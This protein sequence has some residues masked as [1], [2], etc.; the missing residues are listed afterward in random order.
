MKKLFTS[1]LVAIAAFVPNQSKADNLTAEEARTAAA[2]YLM[3]RS[4]VS[5][6]HASEMVLVRQIDNPT[7]GVPAIYFFNAPK[8]G[9]VIMA[10]STAIDP[11]VAYSP[12]GTLD[13]DNLPEN[14]MWWLNNYAE[15]VSQVQILDADHKL[16]ISD[17]WAQLASHNLP[18]A[19]ENKSVVLM[20][21]Y[22][23]QGDDRSPS[24]NLYCPVVDGR[25]SVVGCV[26]TALSQMCH[27]YRYPV[28]PKGQ[29]VYTTSGVTIRLKYD[30]ISFDYSL[31]PNG[32]GSSS[33]DA[34]IKEVA[35]LC[36]A[37]GVA[38]RMNYHPDGSG[39][40]NSN[41]M[42]GM[43]NIFKYEE[44]E[45]MN[46]DAVGAQTFV[47][48]IREELLKKNILYMTGSSSIGTGADAAG[49]A[50]LCGGYQTE[51][52]NMY[53]MNWGWGGSRYGNGFYNLVTNNM[54]IA[55]M[56][57]NF[58]VD[59]SILLGLTPPDDSNRF[60]VGITDVDGV[61]PSPAYPNPAAVNVNIPY[62]L[63]AAADLCIYGLDGRQV[64]KV[65]VPAGEGEATISVT[66]LPAGI[67]I[68]RL[69]NT[70]G[71][72]IVK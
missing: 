62:S 2:Y 53:W 5:S 15:N 25:T 52:L 1:F 20:D 28:Q 7:L 36:Y 10:A 31:M 22:W 45:L 68:Y 6:F 8:D 16:P 49:H 63:D 47:N 42:N 18:S 61:S 39:S 41:A 56:G 71:K 60:A 66:D 35:K 9:W 43:K 59:Q 51:D 44:S 13:A 14:M 11:V 24:Y 54:Y 34:Q 46:R 17:Q 57:Y 27:Y 29:R 48:T 65:A 37:M 4:S 26:A 72:F 33:T 19:K 64:A 3:Q 58:K 21:E 55:S 30:T 67:Y 12:N 70:A 23:S 50:W 32:L 40:N 69:K 38:V